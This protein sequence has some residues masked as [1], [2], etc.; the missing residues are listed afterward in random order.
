MEF[1]K[2]SPFLAAASEN[3]TDSNPHPHTQRERETIVLHLTNKN[4]ILALR[5]MKMRTSS[6]KYI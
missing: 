6:K 1:N 2:D 4:V 5:A 3:Y